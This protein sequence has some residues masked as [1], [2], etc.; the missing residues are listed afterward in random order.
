[1]KQS[2]QAFHEN[3]FATAAGS[4]DQIALAWPHLHIYIGENGFTVKAFI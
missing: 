1:L 2:D 4:N 3:G